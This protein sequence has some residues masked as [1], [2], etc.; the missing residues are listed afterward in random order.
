MES[1]EI[2]GLGKETNVC[3]ELAKESTPSQT[4]R[5]IRFLASLFISGNCKPSKD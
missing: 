2:A 4:L 1:I 5:V 3:G